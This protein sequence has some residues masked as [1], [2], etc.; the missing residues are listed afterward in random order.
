MIYLCQRTSKQYILL[1]ASGFIYNHLICRYSFCLQFSS[2]VEKSITHVWSFSNSIYIIVLVSYLVLCDLYTTLLASKLPIAYSNS[3]M[4]SLLSHGLMHFYINLKAGQ[5]IGE[6]VS[7]I[8]YSETVYQKLRWILIFEIISS[9]QCH[10]YHPDGYNQIQIAR[11]LVQKTLP[12][13][14]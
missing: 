6:Y 9:Q 5:R 8:I 4:F 1:L 14:S 12:I 7:S 13:Y 10:S 3:L 11:D 2:L